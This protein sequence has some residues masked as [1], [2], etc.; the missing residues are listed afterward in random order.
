MYKFVMGSCL[1]NNYCCLG[2]PL[3]VSYVHVDFII[4]A[5][6]Q[7]LFPTC[8]PGLHISMQ[9][10]MFGNKILK[11]ARVRLHALDAQ[12]YCCTDVLWPCNLPSAPSLRPSVRSSL[13]P[14]VP[15]PSVR[16][17]VRSSVSPSVRSSVRPYVRPSVRPSVP[18]SLHPY[19][20][21][22]LRTN[23]RLREFFFGDAK[24]SEMLDRVNAIDFIQNSTKLEPS[25]AKSSTKLSIN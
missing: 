14:S 22:T 3:S 24:T 7:C 4:F 20:C 19:V 21:W 15:R 10:G 8:C 9:D 6:E 12:E 2:V 17:S 23:F 5:N 1:E 13:R 18:P 11:A 16:P 25:S